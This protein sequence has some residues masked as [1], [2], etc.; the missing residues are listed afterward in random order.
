MEG[1]EGEGDDGD[2]GDDDGDDGDDDG[3]DG[4][5]GNDGD[6][7]GTM[8]LI[9]DCETVLPFGV[10]RGAL[11]GLSL[12]GDLPPVNNGSPFVSL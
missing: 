5:G 2:E 4:D 9:S 6:T 7:G 10:R 11:D 1:E 3:D 12:N 8:D